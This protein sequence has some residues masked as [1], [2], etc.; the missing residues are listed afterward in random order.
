MSMFNP[1]PQSLAEFRRGT[2]KSVAKTTYA[3]K[4]KKCGVELK[5]MVGRK[6]YKF[7]GWVCPECATR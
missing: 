1:H 3:Y 4:C 7:G 5:S 2:D 6:K